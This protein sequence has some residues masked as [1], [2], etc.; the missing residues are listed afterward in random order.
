[1]I[2]L[3]YSNQ[4]SRFNNRLRSLKTNYELMRLL[5]PVSIDN[6]DIYNIIKTSTNVVVKEVPCLL[7]IEGENI[8]MFE[9]FDKTNEYIDEL[10]EH[11]ESKKAETSP[12]VTD[13]SALG[14]VDD[15]PRHD[16]NPQPV[17]KEK[18]SVKEQVAAMKSERESFSISSQ[19][20]EGSQGRSPIQITSAKQTK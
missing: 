4:D 17:K 12:K 9:G 5:N 3:L 8:S 16:T 15:S 19:A 18:M 7:D 11:L 6:K 20:A 13:L 14:L 2:I 10:V 1:M